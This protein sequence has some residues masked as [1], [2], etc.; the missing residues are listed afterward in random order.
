MEKLEQKIANCRHFYERQVFL[1]DFWFDIIFR[2]VFKTFRSF[3]RAFS[4]LFQELFQTIKKS[5]NKKVHLS[6]APF[7]ANLPSLRQL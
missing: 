1:D 2:R 6:K 5:R 4:S 7:P 3:S